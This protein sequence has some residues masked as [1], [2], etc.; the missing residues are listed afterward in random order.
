MKAGTCEQDP[1]FSFSI[2][3]LY[4]YHYA[5]DNAKSQ[6]DKSREL[7]KI[8]IENS[9]DWDFEKLPRLVQGTQWGFRG[10]VFKISFTVFFK[11][12]TLTKD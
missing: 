12:L 8:S 6:S 4:P 7:F 1:C 10:K 2:F 9:W 11:N 3:M 5:F